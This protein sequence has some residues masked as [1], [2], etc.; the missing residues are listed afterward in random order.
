ME[1]KIIALMYDFD[2]TLATQDMQNFSFI[3]SLGL[4][5]KEFWEKTNEYC[6]K[7]DADRILGY[8]YVMIEECKKK[9]IKLTYNYL[10]SLGKDVTF[11]KGVLT[12]FDRINAYAKSKGF[13]CEHYLVSSGNSEI[14]EGTQIAKEF[15]HIFGCEYYY[16]KETKE[17]TWPKFMVNYTQ[18]TQCFF[19]ISKGI[20]KNYDDEKVNEKT[21]IRR[22]PYRNMI[23]F[24]DGLTDV[25]IMIL[26]KNNGGTAIAVYNNQ[27]DKEKVETL[28]D[29][30]RVNFYCKADYSEN[31]D[32]EK[33]VK[34]TIDS[35]AIQHELSDKYNTNQQKK[36]V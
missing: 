11:Y 3:P 30:D 15:K 9:G 16:D 12:W 23:Y 34:L 10:K 18:K 5:P 33:F 29:D 19:K 36:N 22:I 28:Y 8:M 6:E 35:I 13:K 2:R 32:L 4:T 20:T 17:A 27:K 21:H 24:G 1:K 31:K 7:Y 25:P 14:I 26:T